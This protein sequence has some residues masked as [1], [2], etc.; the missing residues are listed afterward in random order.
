MLHALLGQVHL[1]LLFVHVVIA[2]LRRFA[3]QRFLGLPGHAR[4]KAVDADVQLRRILGGPRNDQRRA[5]FVDQDRVDL[6]D[7]RIMQATLVAL[8]FRYRHV[9][10]QVIETE[11]VVGAVSDVGVVRSG[12]LGHVHAR[13]DH[14]DRKAEEVVHLAHP[15]RVALGQVV[16]DGD[17]VHALAFQRVE[18]HRQRRHQR[19]ALAG[20]HLGDL[21]LVQDHAADQLHVVVA[22]PQHPAA[23]LAHHRKGLGQDLVEAL[24]VGDALLELG[25]LAA[26]RVVVELL[27]FGFERADARHDFRKLLEHALVAAAED[28]RQDIGHRTG[29]AVPRLRLKVNRAS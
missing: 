28:T 5:R 8:V 1:F 21:A 29:F 22:Q 2:R 4:N 26:Q 11:F 19:L 24:A 20:A 7:D 18:V 10:A 27:H 12:L 13:P 6:V 16:I 23:G 14:A 17:D 25:G 15:C 9:V 3:G